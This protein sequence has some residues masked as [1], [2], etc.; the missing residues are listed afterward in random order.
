MET[1]KMLKSKNF[2]YQSFVFDKARKTWS[3]LYEEGK[4]VGIISASTIIEVNGK[5]LFLKD[6][7]SVT[8]EEEAI[9]EDELGKRL[10]FLVEF[11]FENTNLLL[12]LHFET[13]TKGNCL[14]ISSELKNLSDRS[15]TLVKCSLIAIESQ[16]NGRIYLGPDVKEETF[17]VSSGTTAP[18]FIKKISSNGGEHTSKTIGHIY[19]PK[20]EVSLNTSFLT[21][22]RA[23]TEHKLKYS[24]QVGIES[25]R[26]FCDFDGY[27]LPPGKSIKSEKVFIELSSNPHKT[28]EKWAC[29]VNLVYKPKI[30]EEMS[31]DWCGWAWVD[32]FLI[33][34]YENVVLRNLKALAKRLSDFKIDHI[35][36]SLGTIKGATPGKWLKFNKELFP[37][38]MQWI[39][40]KIKEKGIK[41]G[42][43]FAPFWMSQAAKEEVE[44]NKDNLLKA[45]DGSPLLYGRRWTYGE[46]H[47]LPEEKR[48]DFY[49]LDGS[50]PKTHAYLRKVLQYYRKLGIGYYMID[51]LE[52]G[53][54]STPGKVLY[55]EYFG[56]SK[57]MIKGPEVY[58][59]ALKVV[60]EAAGEDTYL[61]SSSGPTLQNVGL[62]DAARIGNDYCEGRPLY[63]GTYFYPAT[64]VIGGA[65][66]WTSHRRALQNM[67]TVYFTHNRL[68]HNSS[69]LMT[70]DKPVP[71]NEAEITATIFG[72]NGGPVMLGDDIDKIHEE[73]LSLIKK[74]LPR[75]TEIATPLDLFTSVY[76]DYPKV[77]HL[78]VETKWG[79][80]HLL[81]IFNLNKEPLEVSLSTEEMKLEAN[82]QYH[83]Y[84]FWNEEYSGI[85]KQK[86]K[87][88]VPPTSVKL[89]R[90]SQVKKHP[91]LLSTDMHIQQGKVEISSLDWD[92]NTLTLEGEAKRP[93]GERGNILI[94]AP[95]GYYVKKPDTKDLWIAKHAGEENLIIR[96]E[97]TFSQPEV[98]WELQFG[99]IGK[100]GERLEKEQF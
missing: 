4:E 50:H 86:A 46:S 75:T 13:F 35:W 60:R 92:E 55:D 3:F 88:F 90:F 44:E 47:R 74:C 59:A 39:L 29:L 18:N 23:N 32:P 25:Y 34:P 96:K 54:G 99:Q 97:I 21:F 6:A 52:A 53:S 37:H 78:A 36:I 14:F 20:S 95:K 65:D 89:Y 80:W 24:P 51:F 42:F 26:V 31:I 79:R 57:G 81:A 85:L 5:D 27:R 49:V 45:K 71:K 15:F 30:R 7:D 73:R 67:A 66:F 41:P 33:E 16:K 62:V 69:N 63:P 91:W 58:R 77:F 68:Y 84:D 64:Y 19:N 22:S 48:P 93:K 38:G 43:W 40:D 28:L 8:F 17:F 1:T 10:P 9:I 82:E 94:I 72:I 2:E 70:V 61:L 87:F 98:C 83:C 11:K 56:K 100:G 76:P 12:S